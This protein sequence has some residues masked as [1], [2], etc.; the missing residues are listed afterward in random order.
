MDWLLAGSFNGTRGFNPVQVSRPGRGYYVVMAR[1]G[2]C[3][4]WAKY[5][6]DHK[7]KKWAGMCLWYRLRLPPSDVWETRK[8]PE[9]FEAVPGWTEHQ[10]WSYATRHDD[11]GRNWRTARRALWFSGAALTISVVD[12]LAAWLL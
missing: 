10:H 8:C 4:L 7:E 6:E 12:R 1:C 9:F 3:G 2:R 11:L 5:S